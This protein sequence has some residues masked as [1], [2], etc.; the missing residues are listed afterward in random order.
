MLRA[1]GLEEYPAFG[2]KSSA[3]RKAYKRTNGRKRRPV[4]ADPE[5]DL[6]VVDSGM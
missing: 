1:T 4:E 6:S 5:P 2:L 3:N